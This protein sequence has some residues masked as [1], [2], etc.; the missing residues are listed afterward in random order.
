MTHHPEAGRFTLITG[1]SGGIGLAFAEIAAKAGHDLILTARSAD[2]L[3]ELAARLQADHGIRAVALP[4]DLSEPDAP[5]DLWDRA[6]ATGPVG[7]LVNNAGLGAS[8][9]F[10][11]GNW[12]R[13]LAT[14]DVN[15]RALT[16]LMNCA[17]PHMRDT[18]GGRILN[19][20]SLAGFMPGPNLAVYHATKAYV[21][22]LSVA[23]AQELRG[24]GVT[25]TALCPGATKSD[26][27]DSAGIEGAW[28]T[29]LGPMPTAA[30]VASAGWRGA[31]AGRAVVV[32][33]LLNKATVLVTRLLPRTLMAWITGQAMK[34]RG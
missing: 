13:E 22:S 34:A 4:A 3:A 14:I 28:V 23:V 5:A 11:S 12:S 20:A 8:G 33:G 18:G 24:S 26:F 25:V 7:M 21:L 27:F 16:L 30:S 17:I 32:P 9:C 6:M 10:A 2:K 1:A 15:M 19:V 31:M 29:R